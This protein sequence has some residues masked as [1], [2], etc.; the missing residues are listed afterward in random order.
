MAGSLRILAIS[1]YLLG[2]IAL[3]CGIAWKR[4]GA[5]FA[6]RQAMWQDAYGSMARANSE[7]NYFGV[8]LS[9]G[10]S[11]RMLAISLYLL[12]KIAL[13]RGIAWKRAEPVLRSARQWTVNRLLEK[14]LFCTL[15]FSSEGFALALRSRGTALTKSSPG[16]AHAFGRSVLFIFSSLAAPTAR[17][18]RRDES[19]P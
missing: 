5:G 1:L 10:R 9:N 7:S 18:G 11:L 2:K 17:R 6:V 13:R 15:R 3:R 14:R 16:Y 12:G 4:A 8:L 19:V